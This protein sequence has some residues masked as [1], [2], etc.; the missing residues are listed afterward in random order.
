MFF[1]NHVRH[2]STISRNIHFSFFLDNCECDFIFYYNAYFTMFSEVLQ[3]GSSATRRARRNERGAGD[4]VLALCWE[5]R[6][7][8]VKRRYG[9]KHRKR[10]MT[11]SLNSNNCRTFSN[12]SI[13]ARSASKRQ[14]RRY[15]MRGPDHL[16]QGWTGVRKR[17][18]LSKRVR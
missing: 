2:I 12:L 7:F 10:K 13:V 15:R 18:G 14:R 16:C 9:R 4:V 8:D 17:R 3:F 1:E 5:Q 6:W 11:G